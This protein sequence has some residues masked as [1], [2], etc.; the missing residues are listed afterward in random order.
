LNRAKCRAGYRGLIFG[1]LDLRRRL[2][3]DK[4]ID[5]S[6]ASLDVCFQLKPFF[7]H[8]P[9]HQL[10]LLARER[11]AAAIRR[12]LDVIMVAVDPSSARR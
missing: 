12:G 9:D 3:D 11:A 1:H 5:L 7:E 8:R 4:V 2:H 10:D 6:F